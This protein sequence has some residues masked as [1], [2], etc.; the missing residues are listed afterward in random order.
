MLL[1]LLCLLSLCSSLRRHDTSIITVKHVPFCLHK[2]TRLNQAIQIAANMVEATTFPGTAAW[3]RKQWSNPTD[4]FTI[5]LIIG[6]DVVQRAIAQLSG[7]RLTPVS[8]SFGWV[9]IS[10]LICCTKLS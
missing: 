7:G 5:L 3:L 9:R 2:V 1:N 10:T 8:F 4:I 6:G